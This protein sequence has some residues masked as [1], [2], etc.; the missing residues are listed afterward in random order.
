MNCLLL[1]L[2]LVSDATFGRG[3]GMAGLVDAE[4]QA[5]RFG[6]PYLSGKSLKG[7]LQEEC[8]NILY[9]LRL[10]GK[11]T[12]WLDTAHRLFGRPGSTVTDEA[13]M[14]VGSALLPSSL[15]QAVVAAVRRQEFTPGQVLDS[16]TAV[17]RQTAI[18]PR[19]GA[20]MDNTLRAL[21]VILRGC[22]FESQLSFASEPGDRDL[23]LLAACVK[24]LRR[25]GTGRNRG[26]GEL[27]ATLWDDRGEEFT[28]SLFA[29]FRRE[30]MAH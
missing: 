13:L 17:R 20:A 7:L 14:H 15:R 2:T 8:A 27:V 3:E 4:V 10:Q 21:R 1:R 26:R 28:P 29:F 19:T 12:P 6:L 30:V 18:D 5:D 23:A 25:G 9:S 16:L 24:G 22:V 11:D